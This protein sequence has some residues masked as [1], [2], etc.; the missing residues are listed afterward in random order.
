MTK[1]KRKG[2]NRT[3]QDH[4]KTKRRY[5]TRINKTGAGTGHE[6]GQDKRQDRTGQEKTFISAVVVGVGAE[7][8]RARG[9]VLAGALA[10][11]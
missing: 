3:R 11:P 7:D 1:K 10:R 4:D 5:T 9:M 2:K 6:A 8:A